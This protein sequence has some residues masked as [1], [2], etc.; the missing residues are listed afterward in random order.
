LLQ[1]DIMLIQETINE[2]AT[3]LK[4]LVSLDDQL[5]ALQ[6]QLAAQQLPR[7]QRGGT[8]RWCTAEVLTIM[9]YGAWLGLTDKAK[10]YY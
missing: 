8:P 3:L 4:L 2:P 7:D 10:L 1:E 6:P 9:I 5:Q